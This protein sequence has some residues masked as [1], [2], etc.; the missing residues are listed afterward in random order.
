MRAGQVGTFEYYPVEDRVVWDPMTIEIFGFD[1]GDAMG[2]DDVRA[3]IDPEDH[4]GWQADLA[5]ALDP[6]GPGSHNVEVRITRRRDGEVRWVEGQ[7]RTSFENGQATAM[8]GTLRDITERRRY[9]ERLR[10]LNRELRHRV[11][12]LFGVVQGLIA[13]SARGATEV[14]GFVET[15]RARIDALAAAHLVGVAD[16]QLA[17]V[18][19]REILDAVTGPYRAEA[20]TSV[21]GP[22]IAL[23]PRLV[24]PI[25]LVLHELATNAVKH[26]A[27]SIAGGRVAVTWSVAEDG[28][29][30]R[31][32]LHWHEAAPIPRRP[33]EP[34][35]NGF[36]GRLIDAS[37]RQAQGTVRREW[38]AE[39]LVVHVSVPLRQQAVSGEP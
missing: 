11:K 26:G 20:P 31:L 38:R 23:P 4:A 35:P 13:T 21:E 15:L 28:G 22:D 5:A 1:P 24:T 9:E 39:G 27:W 10:L 37:V 30:S 14:D 12:N 18:P 8:L 17:P 19:L 33:D 34:G 32:H 29:A 16:E 25:G 3:V 2:L 7:G 36:G 6:D